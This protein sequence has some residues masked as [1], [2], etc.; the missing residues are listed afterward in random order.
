MADL[1]HDVVG[2]D[3]DETKL[4][5]LRSGE[6]PFYEPGLQEI[7]ERNI[8]AGRLRFSSSYEEAASFADVHFL[9]VGTPQRKDGLAADLT[10]VDAA[11]DKFGATVDQTSRD[12]R[13]VNC[14]GGDCCETGRARPRTG[15]GRGCR[16]KSPGILSSSVRGLECTTR[17]ILIGSYSVSTVI[18]L[19]ELEE[20]ARQVYAPLLE[21]GIPLLVTDLATAELTK[22]AANV[23][24]ATKISFINAMSEMCEH[25]GADVTMLAEAVGSDP[26][27]GRRFLQAGIGYGGGCLTK[28]IRAFIARAQESGMHTAP[29]IFRAVDDINMRRRAH[30]V[31]VV[32]E[33]CS[34]LSGATVG[35]LGVAFKPNSDDVRDSPAL[36]IAERVRALGATVRVFD[37]RAMENARAQHPFLHYVG[38]MTDAC[39]GADVVLVLTEWPEFRE[40]GDRLILTGWCGARLCLMDATA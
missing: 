3:V 13:Q 35:V 30:A 12:L 4:A 14:S 24:L 17:C 38:S 11:I 34:P 27:I 33:M 32:R 37:P 26:R 20:V 22:A 15:S 16:P 25:A 21:E 19:G 40:A 23:F 8:D 7:F 29:I 18:G 28:D 31:D 2:V 5:K 36:E 1:G 10:Y 9:A 39:A 6:V